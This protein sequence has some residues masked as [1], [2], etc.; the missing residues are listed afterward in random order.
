MTG[1]VAAVP[2]ADVVSV[3]GGAVDAVGVVV[4]VG[5][6]DYG[7]GSTNSDTISVVVA[8]AA[9]NSTTKSITISIVTEDDQ[10]PVISSLT[11]NKASNIVSLLTSAQSNTVTFTV[12]VTVVSI[13][14]Y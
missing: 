3:A 4:S 7:V 12:T 2:V 9:G 10:D 13:Y 11:S 5:V 6:G 14:C 1:L 8:D